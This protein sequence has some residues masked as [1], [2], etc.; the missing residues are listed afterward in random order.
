MGKR[1]MTT[2][3]E[4]WRRRLLLPAYSISEAARYAKAHPSTVSSWF[5]RGGSL[6]PALQGREVRT[7]LSYLQLVEVAFAATARRLGLSLREIRLT[8][9]YLRQVFH[10][11]F[12][13]ATR[14]FMTEGK[15]MLLELQQVEPSAKLDL[16]VIGSLEGQLAWAPLM[17]ARFIE[18]EYADDIAVV[19]HVGGPE[20]P[21]RID[22]RVSFGAPTVNGIPTWAVRG[23]F[24]A[25]EDIE[26]IEDDFDLEPEAIVAALAFEG[27]IVKAA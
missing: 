15:R 25:G 8:R 26:D 20:S 1:V 21:V 4:S 24:E 10:E 7:P 11:E 14:R 19:W 13:F 6:G 18:F 27:I 3:V 12:P 22:P 5:T 2:T 9:N 16:L 23:R 17:D